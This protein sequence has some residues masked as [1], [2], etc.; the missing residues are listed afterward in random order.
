MNFNDALKSISGKLDE[1]YNR[2]KGSFSSA[3]YILPYEM[4]LE[5]QSGFYTDDADIKAIFSKKLVERMTNDKPDDMLKLDEVLD[6]ED[7]FI[8]KWDRLFIRFIKDEKT[9]FKKAVYVIIKPALGI[10]IKPDTYKNALLTQ[11]ALNQYQESEEDADKFNLIIDA[12]ELLDNLYSEFGSNLLYYP[13][14]KVESYTESIKNP[15]SPVQQVIDK[16][17]PAPMF[18]EDPFASLRQSS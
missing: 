14:G 12:K 15:P 3:D 16:L 9:E 17:Q 2:R 4:K 7:S 5:L 10:E 13:N 11:G 8:F 18:G 1:D 6:F